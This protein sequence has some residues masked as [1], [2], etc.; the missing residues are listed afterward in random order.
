MNCNKSFWILLIAL[1][2]STDHLNIF[3][4][5]NLWWDDD[6]ILATVKMNWIWERK[7]TVFFSEC[8]R[9]NKWKVTNKWMEEWMN[10]WTKIEWWSRYHLSITVR[11]VILTTTTTNTFTTKQNIIHQKFITI[12]SAFSTVYC[13]TCAL[14]CL[15]RNQNL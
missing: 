14:Y 1:L 7:Q 5:I 10:E 11:C 6:N 3:W 8:N 12:W 4:C 15:N 2:K 13:T 9:E